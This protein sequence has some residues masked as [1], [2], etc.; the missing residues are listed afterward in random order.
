MDEVR[1]SRHVAET[2]EDY[3]AD[4]DL[5][6]RRLGA[7]GKVDNIVSL[8][9]DLPRRSVLEIGAGEGSILKRLSDVGFGEQLFAL[10][11]SSSAVAA[12]EGKAISRLAECKIFDGYHVPYPD[13]RFDLAILSHVIEHVEHPRLLL[14][15]ASRVATHIFVEVPLEDTIRMPRDFT[16]DSVG[17]LNFYSPKTFR[18]LVQS[19]G[20]SV[21]G[22]R[23][24]NRPK[25]TYTYRAG[26]KGLV[27]YWIKQALLVVVPVL[28]TELFTYH[29]ALVCETLS[30][31]AQ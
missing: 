27:N 12:I 4:P 22:Q 18:R 20:L 26:R 25:E 31:P 10:E 2:Y 15:E 23:V 8:C 5:E 28:A 9:G 14:Y 7:I 24:T 19:C 30:R 17:H 11:I 16:P 21:L 6:W 1:V 29:G 3:Y 13:G